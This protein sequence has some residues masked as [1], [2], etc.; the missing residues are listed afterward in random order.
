MVGLGSVISST[1][2]FAE[3][4][5]NVM[6]LPINGLAKV[7]AVSTIISG[8]SASA[9]GGIQL[10]MNLF[11]EEFLSWGYG[12]DI[13]ARVAAIASGGLDSMPWNGTVVMMFT[14][15]GV[16]YSKGYKYVAVITV[17]L[18]IVTSLFA[19]LLYTVRMGLLG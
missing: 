18:P 16:G 13:I 11:G 9:A 5:D 10:A 7:A 19:A 6:L 2:V 17:I 15:S 1:P 4:R 12:P 3:I 14:L 8:I